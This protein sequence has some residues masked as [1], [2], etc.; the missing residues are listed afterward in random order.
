MN[1]KSR[2]YFSRIGSKEE[3]LKRLK[4]LL[5]RIWPEG[6]AEKAI[7][8]IKIH[9]GERGNRTFIPPEYARVV[10]EFLLA[11][12]ATP[13]LTDTNTL[14][15][16][17]RTVT[18]SHLETAYHNGFTYE[19]VGAPVV[20]ADGLRGESYREVEIKGR[21]YRKVKIGTEIHLA[22]ALVVLTHFKGHELTGF[23]G[24]IKNLGM[25]CSSRE[26]KL[27]QH[28]TTSPHVERSGCT[29]CM[30]CVENCAFGAIDMVEGKALISPERCSGCSQCIAV[31][32]QGTIKVTWN[33]STAHVQR[34]MAEHALGAI[35][36]KEGKAIYLNFLINITPICD[37]YPHSERPFMEDI[38]ILASRDPVAIDQASVDLIN[39]DGRDRFREIHPHIDWEIQLEHAESIGLGRRDYALEEITD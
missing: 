2:V 9:F 15:K 4:W 10:V 36:G 5:E 22:D 16:G 32:P 33:E 1:G 11:R 20:I 39:R 23:G 14:Y 34:K 17:T 26:G 7:T 35:K 3:N 18:P 29:G 30:V 6:I 12:G 25:G 37:C 24:S 21:F 38:G 19:R 31:C 8:A 27:S 28:S 13:F